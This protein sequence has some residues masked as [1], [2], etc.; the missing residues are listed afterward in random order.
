[1]CIRDRYWDRCAE[2][3]Q[4]LPAN[5]RVEYG[6]EVKHSEVQGILAQHDVF[7]FPTRGE[8]FGHVIHEALAAGLFVLLSDQ[9]PWNDV[10]E[11]GAGWVLPLTDPNAFTSAL[12]TIAAWDTDIF[13]NV[14]RIASSFAGERAADD[15]VLEANRA[16]FL[17]VL[18]R[19]TC[20]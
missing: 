20:Q 13:S 19:E 18:R 15:S 11:R 7:L 12:D 1:M 3:I 14:R 2:I 6:G 16:I 5:V 4:T 8:N 17:D 9:T 10:A